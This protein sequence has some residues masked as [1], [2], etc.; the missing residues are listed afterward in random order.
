LSGA[1]GNLQRLERR[2]GYLKGGEVVI[3]REARRLIEE[4]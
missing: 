2:G 4:W 3:W 1:V